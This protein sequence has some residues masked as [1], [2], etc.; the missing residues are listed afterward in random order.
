MNEKI[1]MYKSHMKGGWTHQFGIFQWSFF[2]GMWSFSCGFN[3]NE[4]LDVDICVEYDSFSF[5]PIITNRYFKPCKF[6]FIEYETFV[7]MTVI[8]T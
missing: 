6:E 4:G 2:C 3:I 8:W 7:P 1:F 5:D